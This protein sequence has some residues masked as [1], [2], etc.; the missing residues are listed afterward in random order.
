MA[1]SLGRFPTLLLISLPLLG[2]G[3]MAIPPRLLLLHQAPTLDVMNWSAI[4]GSFRQH[5][6]CCGGSMMIS[7]VMIH[8][9]RD[10]ISRV[11]KRAR[12]SED[13]DDDEKGTHH[14]YALI[15]GC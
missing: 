5:Q 14:H 12:N 15:E 2:V 11:D 4:W 8:A 1:Q 9:A 3:N 7:H 10:L 13:L 6:F